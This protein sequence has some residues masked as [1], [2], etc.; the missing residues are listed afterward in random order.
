[1]LICQRLRKAWEWKIQGMQNEEIIKKMRAEG[2]NV[3]KQQMHKIFKNPFYAGMVCHGML[4]GRVIEGKHEK[5]VSR[6]MFMKVNE[7]HMNSSRFGIS[8][9]RENEDI[10]LKVFL[11][12]A[13]CDQPFT[14]YLVKKKNLYYY[15]CRTVG[16]KSNKSAKQL[17][18]QFIKLLGGY[19]VAEDLLEPIMFE[20]EHAYFEYNKENLE[21]GK[22]LEGRIND[23]KTKIYN[24]EES[25]FIRKEMS[26]ETYERFMGMF[27]Q[28]QEEIASE[29]DKC[30]VYISNLKEML[31]RA[32]EFC[33]NISKI[34][35]SGDIEVKTVLQKLLF[36][37]GLLYDRKIGGVRTDKINSVIKSIACLSGDFALN[38]KGL[39]AQFSYQSLSAES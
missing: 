24:A 16:C 31:K 1:M 13:D 20:L 33:R 2:V 9:K 29:K 10:P 32:V 6:E 18:E 26:K 25:Y 8:H 36:P 11:R 27:G 28:E 35:V 22:A 14:G 34:W 38:E 17:H 19:T 21:K 7:I 4:N 39:K 30:S 37:S 12:C 15:K 5:M 3:Y 23:L